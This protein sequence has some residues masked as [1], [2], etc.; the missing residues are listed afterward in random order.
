[1]KTEAVQPQAP[2]KEVPPTAEPESP[3]MQSHPDAHHSAGTPSPFGK[4]ANVGLPPG[5]SMEQM[6][7]QMMNVI[8]NLQQNMDN[9]SDLSE[10]EQQAAEVLK[11]RLSNMMS[12]NE[13]SRLGNLKD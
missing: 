4:G 8:S 13:N 7:H 12:D 10:E 9:A 11:N 1:M 6:Q 3:F 2:P 5:V